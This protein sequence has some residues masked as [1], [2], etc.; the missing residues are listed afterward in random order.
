MSRP[1]IRNLVLKNLGVFRDCSTR[2]TLRKYNLIY[3]FNGSGKTTL[4]RVFGSL[5][6]G[7]LQ[8]NLPDGGTFDIELS[9]GLTLK[10]TGDYS[11]LKGRLLV[12]NVDFIEKNFMWKEGK[13]KPVFYLGQ[14][15]VELAEHLKKISTRENELQTE[16]ILA[17]KNRN[18]KNKVFTTYKRDTAR[19]ISEQLI[20]GRKYEAPNLV[21]DYLAYEYDEAH[22]LLEEHVQLEREMMMRKAPLAQLDL[23]RSVALDSWSLVNKVKAVLDAT[24]GDIIVEDLRD[25]DSMLSWVHEGVSYHENHDLSSCLFCGN[26]LT[27]DRLQSLQDLINGEFD[28]I[29]RTITTLK[30][31]AEKLQDSCAA[32]DKAVPALN[33]LSQSLHAEFGAI[34]KRLKESLSAPSSITKVILELLTEKERSLNSSIGSKAFDKAYNAAATDEGIP[35]QIIDLNNIITKHNVE[36]SNFANTKK[37]A[38][39]KLKNHYLSVSHA[40][41]LA[42]QREEKIAVAKVDKIQNGLKTLT[43]QGLRLRNEVRKH[44]PAAKRTSEMIRNYLGRDE[45]EVTALEEGYQ[46]CRGGQPIKG[47]LSE[48]EKTAIVL[49]YFLSM[50]EAEGRKLKELIVVVDDPISSLDTKALNYSFNILKSALGDVAQLFILTHNLHFMNEA[51]KWLRRHIDKGDDSKSK[52]TLLFLDAIKNDGEKYLSSTIERLPKYIRE[53]ESEYQY[54]FHLILIFTQ[55]P[56]GTEH[57]YLMPNAMRK[58][59]EIFL[60]FKLPGTRGLSDKVADIAEQNGLDEGSLLALDR[61]VQLESHSD[62]LDDLVTFSSMTVEETRDAAEALLKM[63]SAVDNKHYTL[64]CRMCGVDSLICAA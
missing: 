46:L 60:T 27:K 7:I 48:G 23:L 9:D 62:N 12:L 32:I 36:Y 26:A 16:L 55:P 52:A 58:V 40:T 13:A 41:Y 8:A 54:L 2:H 33:E 44:G 59:L 61:L 11:A 43:D 28:K 51:K 4:S 42:Y 45:L 17:E 64:L 37:T 1:I 14:E 21:S 10:S 24:I 20:L 34:A 35:R 56:R 29:T 5:E 22:K 63:M 50:L 6:T 30:T 3:G 53:Y 57:F 38:E 31:E 49:C 47:P 15:Q 39:R 25:H 19:N 18:D